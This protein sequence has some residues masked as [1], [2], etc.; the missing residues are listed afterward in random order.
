MSDLLT[1]TRWDREKLEEVFWL[2]D[3]E[4]IW[5]ITLSSRQRVDK[6]VWHYDKRGEFSVRSAYKVEMDCRKVGS[7]S[8]HGGDRVWW[9]KL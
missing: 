6:W 4:F 5:S 1:T 9:K 7:Q 8:G 3:R 2:I